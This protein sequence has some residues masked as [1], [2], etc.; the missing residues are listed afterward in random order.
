MSGISWL[1]SN[2]SDPLVTLLWSLRGTCWA[3]FVYPSGD[4]CDT[5]L[6]RLSMRVELGS[7]K[8]DTVQLPLMG[9]VVGLVAVPRQLTKMP[10]LKWRG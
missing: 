1:G 3:I 6:Y 9:V 7:S 5:L 4:P 10:C 8:P 2:P